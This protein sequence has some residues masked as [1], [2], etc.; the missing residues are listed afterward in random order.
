MDRQFLPKAARAQRHARVLIA[1]PNLL[2]RGNCGRATANFYPSALYYAARTLAVVRGKNRATGTALVEVYAARADPI[3]SVNALALVDNGD[4]QH[5]PL[6]TSTWKIY[7]DHV[8][9]LAENE[10]GSGRLLGMLLDT[11]RLFS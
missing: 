8:V 1:G 5:P 10:V 11:N 9:V 6:V 3:E 4:T 2:V 7:D